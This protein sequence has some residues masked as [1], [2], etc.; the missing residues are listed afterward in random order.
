[1]FLFPGVSGAA[2][3]AGKHCVACSSDR[4]CCSASVT[5]MEGWFIHGYHG[6]PLLTVC[7]IKPKDLPGLCSTDCNWKKKKKKEDEEEE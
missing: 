5:K 6:L 4:G 3:D 2:L 7:R 1:M